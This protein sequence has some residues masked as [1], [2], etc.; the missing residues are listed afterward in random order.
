MKVK[1]LVCISGADTI[2]V[3]DEVEMEDAEAIRH[4]EAGHVVPV[5]EVKI[6]RAVKA[7]AEKRKK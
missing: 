7:P 1:A 4:I 6:E 5:S 2:N 3:N